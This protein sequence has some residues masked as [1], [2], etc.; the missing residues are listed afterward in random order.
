MTLK[1]NKI[2][3]VGGG[4]AGWMSAATFIKAFPEK[5]VVVVESDDIP[6]IGVGESTVGEFGPWLN[7]LG[8]DKKDFMQYTDAAFKLGIGFTNFKT[9]TSPT[10][11]YPFG[12]ALA[13]PNFLGLNDWVL[14]KCL[15]PQTKN[16]DFVRYYFPHHSSFYTNKIMTEHDP[17]FDV[18]YHPDRDLVF[19]IDA[20][21][22]AMWLYE[23]YCTP[24]GVQRIIGTVK[25]IVNDDSGGIKSL[26]LED[27]Q[28]IF[29]DLFVDCT[30]FKSLLLGQHMKVPFVSTKDYLPNNK[31]WFSPVQYT[32]KEKEMQLFTNCTALKNGWAWNTPLWSRIGTGYVY[33]DDFVSDEDA[34]QE[35]KDYLDSDKMVIHNPNRS[36]DM[37]FRQIKIKNGYYEKALVNNVLGIGLSQAFL[38][39][40]ESTGLM[41][42]HVALM[43][44]CEV[45]LNRGSLTSWDTE[46]FNA[47]F[48]K[49]VK[50]SFDFVTLHFQ[51]TQRDD[52]PYWN[53]ISSKEYKNANI[54]MAVNASIN[55]KLESFVNM[56]IATPGFDYMPMTY[57]TPDLLNYVYR[58]NIK[59][60]LD[61]I[62]NQREEKIK[63]WKEIADNSFSHYEYLKK[64]IYN[65]N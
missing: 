14:K 28:E 7:F 41:F 24:R 36:K 33:C 51:L 6:R 20:N 55:K 45:L 46:T 48:I 5:E 8:I 65:S 39:P 62:F 18:A 26:I 12:Q 16:D 1:I 53:H 57:F 23:K 49:R 50:G 37:T 32:D 52:S 3:I 27:G 19:Q 42:I 61:P 40:L 64:Y 56:V 30:G 17:S 11:F 2:V 54:E 38:E 34:L 43:D 13:D 58:I 59:D 15:Y 25:G 47:S 9:E 60:E 44:F 21:K 4:S 31:A 22:F 29:G 35:F 63:I 10:F